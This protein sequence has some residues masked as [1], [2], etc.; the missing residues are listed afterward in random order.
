MKDWMAPNIPLTIVV[1]TALA[2]VVLRATR[3]PEPGRGPSTKP[4]PVT[5]PTDESQLRPGVTAVIHNGAGR[6]AAG[7][8]IFHELHPQGRNALC[9]VCDGQY[10][11]A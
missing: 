6:E 7:P 9:T 11:S 1:F 5:G 4:A 8:H 3:R 2:V 10:R